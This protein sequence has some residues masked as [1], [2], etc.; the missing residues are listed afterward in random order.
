MK[1]KIVSA[2]PMIVIMI[3]IFCFSAQPSEQSNKSSNYIVEKIAYVIEYVN[4]VTNNEEDN[5]P[6]IH[7]EELTFVIRKLAHTLE[8]MALG[9]CIHMHLYQYK[10]R[11]KYCIGLSIIIGGIYAFTDEYHQSFVPGRSCELRDVIIDTNGIFLGV[12]LFLV[13]IRILKKRKSICKE[14]SIHN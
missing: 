13:A 10:L 5:E 6:V 12:I 7:V 1:I 14:E 2:I 9:F 4:E 3:I 11:K 8:Y